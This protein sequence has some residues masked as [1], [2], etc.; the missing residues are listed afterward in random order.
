MNTMVVHPHKGVD[1][2]LFGMS[3]ADVQQAVGVSPR[4]LERNEFALPEDV[5]QDSGLSVMYD[6]AGHC[7]AISVARG[8]VELKYDGYQLFN[9]P[10][11]DV[12]RWAFSKD[13]QL[14]PTDGFI[15]KLLGLGMWADWIDEP[16]I[17]PDL[18]DEP[19]ASFI[20][21]REGYYEYER[22]RIARMHAS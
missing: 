1:G 18:A 12:R 13:P 6:E 15:S 20:I 2:I 3:R 11:H 10:S 17:P 14:D 5:F 19:A 22:D 4:R 7:H 16:D 8:F 9:H 21:F